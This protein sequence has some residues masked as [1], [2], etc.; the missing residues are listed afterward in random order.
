MRTPVSSR[1]HAWCCVRAAALPVVLALA[2]AL[3]CVLVH[4][5]RR[6]LSTSLP[7]VLPLLPAHFAG[8]REALVDVEA[9]TTHARLFGAFEYAQRTGRA[10]DAQGNDR[11]HSLPF[12]TGDAFRH[13][14]DFVIE[15]A[16]DVAPVVHALADAALPL[17][18]VLPPDAAFIVLV[19]ADWV[20]AFLASTALETSTHPLVLV[21]HNGDAHGPALDAPRLQHPRLVAVFA[22]NCLGEGPR[23]HCL[24]IGLPNIRHA[25][26]G[27]SPDALLGSM[28]A[29]ATGPAPSDIAAAAFAATAA[30]LP[31]VALAHAC[32]DPSTH[33]A[34]RA[35]L[36]DAIDGDR[37]R[38]AW[39]SRS[40]YGAHAAPGVSLTLDHYR[41]MTRT[42]AVIAPRGNGLDTHRAWEA[43]LLGRVLVTRT[44]SLDPL[45]AGFPVL[46]L[47]EW[48]DL[49]HARV[50]EAIARFATPGAR[51]ASRAAT[52]RLFAPWHL[53][54]I[55]TA[56]RRASEFCSTEAL[57]ATLRSPF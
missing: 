52:P 28:L 42:A 45:W 30:H 56:A 10:V 21:S 19:A 44:S 8:T 43:L 17:H 15:E 29:A 3:A 26:G 40:C 11:R 13:A 57:F 1:P 35:P 54:A 41:S 34:E 12:L 22:Q 24:P 27:S 50:T 14:A 23:F 32:F 53:C 20:P 38:F 48:R 55:G 39:V 33:A 16:R 7:P 36:L 46:V 2:L 6:T 9:L 18:A 49:S 4:A 25:G 31:P 5:R 47:R 51:N 37:T